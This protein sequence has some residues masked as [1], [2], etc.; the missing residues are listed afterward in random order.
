MKPV[1]DIAEKVKN[2][3]NGLKVKRLVSAA[4]TVNP[5]IVKASGGRVY[6]I[7]GQN[8]AAAIKYIKLYNKATAPAATDTPVATFAVAASAPFSIEFDAGLYFS[9]GIGY[10]LTGANADDDATA[11]TAADILALNVFYC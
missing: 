4:A 3:D 11:L 5:T 7:T 9:A 10:R 2:S 6:K 1:F 8:A